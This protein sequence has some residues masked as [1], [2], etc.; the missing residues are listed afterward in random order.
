MLVMIAS[1]P[2]RAPQRATEN[3]REENSDGGPEEYK[4]GDRESRFRRSNTFFVRFSSLFSLAFPAKRDIL[5]F[6][7]SCEEAD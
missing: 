7:Y 5:I 2:V 3:R 6:D 1:R 4:K